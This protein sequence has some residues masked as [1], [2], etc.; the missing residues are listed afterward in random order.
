MKIEVTY[1]E[2][3]QL[4]TKRMGDRRLLSMEI[5]PHH[6]LEAQISSACTGGIAAIMHKGLKSFI[7]KVIE[8]K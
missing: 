3:I 1:S 7:V 6:S 8:E 4:T 2:P 5:D